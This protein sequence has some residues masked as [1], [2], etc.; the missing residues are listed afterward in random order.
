MSMF[1]KRPAL[2]LISFIL[3]VFLKRYS[4]FLSL[5]FLCLSLLSL[6]FL[7]KKGLVFLLCTLLFT[8]GGLHTTW[9]EAIKTN[10]ASSLLEETDFLKGTVISIPEKENYGK[11]A[12]VSVGGVKIF[13]MTGQDDIKYKDEIMFKGSFS[14]PDEKSRSF[15]FDYPS[16]LKS[17]GIY[18]TCF[19]EEIKVLEN[20]KSSFNIV[21]IATTLKEKLLLKADTLWEGEALMFARAIL[22]GDTSLSSDEFRDKVA[23][24]SISHVISVSG[25][26]V[27]L[28]AA[29]VMFLMNKISQ[30]R[31]YLKFLT[32]PFVCFFVIMVSP[33]PSAMRSVLMF[34]IFIFAWVFLIHYDAITS[35]TI[36]ATLILIYNPFAAFSLNFLLSFGAMLGIII[37]TKPFIRYLKF[38]PIAY[39]TDCLSVT[40]ASQVFILPI[41]FFYFGKIP[42]F[43]LFANL[44][45]VPLVPFIMGFGYFALIF[46]I[47][48]FT[49]FI[50]DLLIRSC[51]KIAEFFGSLPFSNLSPVYQNPVLLWAVFISFFLLMIFFF[52]KGNKRIS[53]VLLNVFLIFI[54]LSYTSPLLFPERATFHLD[55]KRGS[56]TLS[57]SGTHSVILDISSS[58]KDFSIDTLIPYLKRKGHSSLDVLALTEYNN[59]EEVLTFL[60]NFPVKCLIVPENSHIPMLSDRAKYRDCRV[61][62]ASENDIYKIGG[63]TLFV[64]Y[65]ALGKA[66]YI[67]SNDKS[68]SLVTGNI[69]IYEETALAENLSAKGYNI[70]VLLAPRNGNKGS[71]TPEL[72]E[73]AKPGCVIAS[74]SLALSEDFT[75]RLEGLNIMTT[76]DYGDITLKNGEIIPYKKR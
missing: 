61:I 17:K 23:D 7:K 16:Y 38:I 12:V 49:D 30:K 48:L 34:I 47:P 18:I 67:L 64:P 10:D 44:L 70:D 14:L 59:D 37:F 4:L 74:R 43:S 53:F 71:C 63:I 27:S 68:A 40:L 24:G 65:E 39:I 57:V 54:L 22:L 26:H 72:L 1:S 58:E 32:I 50:S 69:S 11:S 73:S 6:V 28:V 15:D 46:P 9:T 29:A 13:L 2:T 55:A 20:L 19:T 35:L 45:V 3:G 21:D 8:A 62:Y 56:C 60:E 52:L 51:I 5:V 76:K 33:V 25:T 31:R 36:A 75:K 66:T 41:I 42:L